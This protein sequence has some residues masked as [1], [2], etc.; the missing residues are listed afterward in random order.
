MNENAIPRAKTVWYKNA[1]LWANIITVVV[2][3]LTT[4]CGIKVPAELQAGILAI[5]NLI[6]Q[7]PAMT[8]TKA[9]ADTHN[10]SI[11]SRMIQ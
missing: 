5:V 8:S 10:R 6:L 9:K 1:T 2:L 7:A 4:Y 11:R 3:T